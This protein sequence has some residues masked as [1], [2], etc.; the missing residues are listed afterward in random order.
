[1][2][3]RVAALLQAA[4]SLNHEIRRSIEIAGDRTSFLRLF[5]DTLLL[6]ALRVLGLPVSNRERTV[7]L[8]GDA[9]ITYRLNRGD[10]Q[11]LREVWMDEHYRLPLHLWPNTAIDLGANIGLTSVWLAT[12]LGCQRILAIEPSRENA[13]LLSRNLNQNHIVGEVLS[14]AVGPTD[15]WVGFAAHEASNLGKTV[16]EGGVTVRMLSMDTIL[17]H[18]NTDEAVDLVKI[19]IEGGEADLFAGDVRWLQRV[20]CIIAEFHPGF[21]D[22]GQIIATLHREGFVYLKESG[23]YLDHMDIFV[24]SADS[25]EPFIR[26]RV[27]AP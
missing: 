2:H 6:R 1:M 25:A 21:V 17:R 15:G 3:H 13:R 10:L 12:R 4:V 20:R 24:Q 11:S 8:R 19:D 23:R 26:P 5:T 22:Y 9:V 18:L 27:S 16:R 14:A 7:R